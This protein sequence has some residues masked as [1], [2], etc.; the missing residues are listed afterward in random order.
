[1]TSASIQRFDPLSV[2]LVGE[3]NPYGMDPKLAL[4]HLPRGASGNRL[5]L[6]L[7]LCDVTYNQLP[8]V[9]LCNGRFS[10]F[11]AMERAEEIL[12]RPYPKTLVLL[13]VKVGKSF[14]T[15]RRPLA[16]LLH[17]GPGSRTDA[18]LSTSPERAMSAVE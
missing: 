3:V 4:Y 7:G 5:R 8:K 15:L 16:Y 9:N 13:G 11:A 1:M 6:I 14:G 17:G 2:L 12:A 18:H 10:V